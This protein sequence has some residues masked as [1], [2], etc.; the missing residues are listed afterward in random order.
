MCIFEG[1]MDRFLYVQIIEKILI[2]F[3]VYFRGGGPGGAFAPHLEIGF[4][5]I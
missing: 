5:Y 1:I 4:P 3:R 2:P